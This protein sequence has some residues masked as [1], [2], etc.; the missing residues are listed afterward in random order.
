MTDTHLNTEGKVLIIIGSVIAL[1]SSLTLLS[2]LII[3]T[4]TVRLNRAQSRT[5]TRA[6]FEVFLRDQGKLTLL[7]CKTP[8][9]Y[10]S[11][12]MMRLAEEGHI[13]HEEQQSSIGIPEEKAIIA[14]TEPSVYSDILKIRTKLPAGNTETVLLYNQ[15]LLNA[16]APVSDIGGNS[17]CGSR[18][19]LLTSRKRTP[20]TNLVDHCDVSPEQASA[21]DSSIRLNSEQGTISGPNEDLRQTC[22]ST[23]EESGSLHHYLANPSLLGGC[24][25][26]TLEE[27]RDE[28]FSA[29]RLDSLYYE[30]VERPENNGGNSLYVVELSKIREELNFLGIEL[31]KIRQERRS[32]GAAVNKIDEELSSPVTEQDGMHVI[33]VLLCEEVKELR[34]KLQSVYAENAKMRDEICAN[35]AEIQELKAPSCTVE[36]LDPSLLHCNHQIEELTKECSFLRGKLELEI[37]FRD[38]QEKKL[39]ETINSATL[40]TNQQIKKIEEDNKLNYEE[41]I[42]LSSMIHSNKKSLSVQIDELRMQQQSFEIKLGDISTSPRN[43][44]RRRKSNLGDLG[45]GDFYANDESPSHALDTSHTLQLNRAGQ[46]APYA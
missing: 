7:P 34:K 16:G 37:S 21:R 1:L 15:E 27:S 12:S 18:E 45:E 23:P 11:S 4:L 33:M 10:T 41:I 6:S 14:Q 30:E 31:S 25:K 20:L 43:K 44:Q 38:S 40:V 35:T 22:K 17:G 5:N 32:L 13:T 3:A 24:E 28:A 26:L 19:T 9:E 36:K 39:R 42:A 46:R 2:S 8:D 29:D